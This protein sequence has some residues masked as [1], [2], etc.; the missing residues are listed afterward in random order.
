M[1]NYVIRGAVDD[2]ALKLAPIMRDFDREE[3]WAASAQTPLEALQ[4]GLETADEVYTFDADDIPFCMFGIS[5]VTFL[6]SLGVPWLLTSQDIVQHRVALLRWSRKVTDHW[7][8]N[9]YRILINFI[10]VRHKPALR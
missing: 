1:I 2:D 9:R 10:D 3:V 4:K 8:K 5:P 7:L 6:G